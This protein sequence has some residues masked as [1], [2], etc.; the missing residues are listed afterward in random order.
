MPVDVLGR[1]SLIRFVLFSA[2]G[3]ATHLYPFTSLP[4]LLRSFFFAFPGVKIYRIGLS[5]APLPIE[6]YISN[7]VC[8]VPLPPQGQVGT[9]DYALA[10]TVNDEQRKGETGPGRVATVNNLAF[11]TKYLLLSVLLRCSL[12]LADVLTR[13]VR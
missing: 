6:R 8:E 3:S 4:H 2:A 10:V 9:L 7:F 12:P 13:R 5:E 11:C 1:R